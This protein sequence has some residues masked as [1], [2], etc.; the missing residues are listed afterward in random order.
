MKLVNLTPHRV[1]ICNAMGETILAVEPSGETAR[2][3]EKFF[4]DEPVITGDVSIPVAVIGR[5][6]D[7][8][9]RVVGIPDRPQLANW[10]GEPIGYAPIT[11]IYVV[12]RLVAELAG[13][14]DVMAPD[15]GPQSVIRNDAGQIVG[16]RRLLAFVSRLEETEDA[17]F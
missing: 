15:T 14:P 5:G 11:T 1:V 4:A 8:R 10:D 13:R 9:P 16:V 6:R 2:I 7:S 3:E 12:S 17:A